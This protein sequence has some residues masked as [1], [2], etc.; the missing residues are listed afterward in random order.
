MVGASAGIMNVSPTFTEQGDVISFQV[1]ADWQN[2]I[3]E[4]G[5]S[6]PPAILGYNTF[7]LGALE[8]LDP[9]VGFGHSANKGT[10]VPVIHVAL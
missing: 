10:A 1:G 8:S 4:P 5:L 3:G 6:V 2:Y 9:P 7:Q